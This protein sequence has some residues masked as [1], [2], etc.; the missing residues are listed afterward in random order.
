M[1]PL[2]PRRQEPPLRAP[3]AV[4]AEPPLRVP[5]QPRPAAAALPDVGPERLPW[6]GPGRVVPVAD[7]PGNPLPAAAAFV[8]EP[9]AATVP[10]LPDLEPGEVQDHVLVLA[11]LPHYPAPHLDHDRDQDG[12]DLVLASDPALSFVAPRRLAHATHSARPASPAAPRM[13]RPRGR[14]QP[15][16]EATRALEAV[17]M[18][19]RALGQD[20]VAMRQARQARRRAA[21]VDKATP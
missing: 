8:P 21:A 10:G 16:S 11:E 18:R 13:T 14:P 6:S 3:G 1:R 15:P 7:V 4:R 12:A 9:F 5:Q 19:L 17:G 20:V 2:T